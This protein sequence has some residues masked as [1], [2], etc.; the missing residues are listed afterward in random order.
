MPLASDVP[1]GF[2][3]PS[4]S[5]WAVAASFF[6]ATLASFVAINLSLRVRSTRGMA[7]AA[8][9]LAGALVMGTGIWSMHFVG[10]Q[11]FQLSIPLGYRGGLTLLSW[12]AAVAASGVALAL[13]G[14]D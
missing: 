8:W 4:Y 10:M 9:W 12:T 11:A 13:P 6:V 14:R 5:A 7:S 1:A 3:T 2:L